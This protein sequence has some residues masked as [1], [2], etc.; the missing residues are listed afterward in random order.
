M[1][2]VASAIDVPA[3]RAAVDEVDLVEIVRSLWARKFSIGLVAALCTCIAGGYAYLSTP[4]YQVKSVLRPASLKDLDALNGTGVYELAPEEALKRVGNALDSYDIRLAFFRAN[5]NLFT[6][7]RKGSESLEQSFERFNEE[8]FKMLQPD[9]RQVEGGSPFV[10]IQLTYPED[11][12]GVA[13]VNSFVA[14]AIQTERDRLDAEL[15][16]IVKNRLEQLALKISS[17]R[18]SY[19]ASKEAKIAKLAE[20][21][22]LKRAVLQDELKALRQ[23]LRALRDNRIAQLDEAIRIAKSLGIVDPTTPSAM[24]QESRGAQGGGVHTEIN[25]RQVPLYFM[26]SA[27]LEAERNILKQRR[28]DDFTSP[29]IA[30]IAKEIRILE[31]N[32]QIEVL[33]QR[34]NED[35]FLKNLAGWKEKEAR[36]KNIEIDFS[37]FNAVNIDQLAIEPLRSVKPKKALIV[38]AGLILGCLLGVF[39]VLM[40]RLIRVERQ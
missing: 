5:E 31:S 32:R 22:K 34:Q 30:E 18:A 39:V 23:Q 26:G 1:D 9:A 37:A 36:L 4:Y 35:L 13:V 28:S 17:E 38:I 40:R 25:S 12:D 19:E 10:G 14:Y 21:D 29:R 27:A 6:P 15:R 33:K 16:T 11:V 2:L 7:L 8:S 3:R 20:S 24:G